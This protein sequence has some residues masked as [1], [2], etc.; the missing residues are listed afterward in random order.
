MGHAARVSCQ[1]QFSLTHTRKA[2]KGCR[3]GRAA[4]GS[5]VQERMVPAVPKPKLHATRAGPSFVPVLTHAHLVPTHSRNLENSIPRL[6]KNESFSWRCTN[7][8][9][10]H[11]SGE[12]QIITAK[13][14][15]CHP[16]RLTSAGTSF[17]L[18]M[19]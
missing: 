9:S 19:Q 8:G 15:D 13:T 12:A 14:H 10:W 2:H 1:A 11:E 5:D 16:T 4:R 7:T 6:F 3:R 17:L 18:F